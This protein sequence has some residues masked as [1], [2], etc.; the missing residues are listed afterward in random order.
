M[1]KYLLVFLVLLT[2]VFVSCQKEETLVPTTQ[3]T[4]QTPSVS[5]YGKW[6]LLDAYMYIENSTTGQK[7]KY[8]HFNPTKLTSSLRYSGAM[9]DFEVIEKNIT[10]WEFTK[11]NQVPGYGKFILNGDSTELYGFYVTQNNWTIVEDPSIT[12]P[13]QMNLGGSS[14]VIRAYLD[15]YNN[16]IVKFYVQEAYENINGYN[17]KYFNE[18]IFQ[19]IN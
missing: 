15:D 18:L 2:T 12:N 17:C 11:P 1:K 8:S 19:K 10:T 7:I 3:D 5:I 14:R 4:T 16:N 6:L 9:I 13:N